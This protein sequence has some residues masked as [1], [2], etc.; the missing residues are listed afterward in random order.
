M[1][2]DFGS[3]A[4]YN[5]LSSAMLAALASVEQQFGVKFETAGGSL[6]STDMVIKIK[7]STSD[8]TAVDAAA[9]RDFG[10]YCRHVGLEPDDFGCEF[11]G[12][13][14]RYRLIGVSLNR[15]KYPIDGECLR[16]G[17]K[18]KFTKSVVANI[19]AGRAA[20]QAAAAKAAAAMPERP[21]FAG[22]GSTF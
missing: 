14:G 6:G 11:S 15:P 3:R 22:A 2:K 9:K 20:R 5:T 17:K 16:T 1:F 13:S 21:I 8:T 10:F 7:A 18:F 4:G 12:S 19:V